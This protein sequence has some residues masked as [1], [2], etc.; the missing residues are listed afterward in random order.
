MVE[1]DTTLIPKLGSKGHP[2][3]D[4]KK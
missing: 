1:A 2:P 3:A 4:P